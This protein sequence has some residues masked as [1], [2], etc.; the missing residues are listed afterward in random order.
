MS[1]RVN[2]GYKKHLFI[3]IQR[4]YIIQSVMDIS[5]SGARQGCLPTICL[6]FHSAVPF[7]HTESRKKADKMNVAAALVGRWRDEMSE[8]AWVLSSDGLFTHEWHIEADSHIGRYELNNHTLTLIYPGGMS[9]SWELVTIDE[10]HLTYR[11]G[12]GDY[13]L[14]KAK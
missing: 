6:R 9:I 13:V 2:K 7:R 10:Q 12:S 8:E 4:D 14:Q 11:T 3:Q 1:L 5:Q